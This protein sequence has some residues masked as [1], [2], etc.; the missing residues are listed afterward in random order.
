[1]KYVASVPKYKIQ[2]LKQNNFKCLHLCHASCEIS[3]KRFGVGY[4]LFARIVLAYIYF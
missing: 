3:E 2:I 1:M 4:T